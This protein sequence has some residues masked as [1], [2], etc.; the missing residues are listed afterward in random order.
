MSNQQ[1][2]VM[3]LVARGMTCREVSEVMAL[4][5]SSVRGHMSGAYQKLGVT[6][7]GAMAAIVVMKDSGWLGAFPRPPQRYDDSR[8]VTPAQ[9]AYNYCFVAMCQERTPR[10]AAI[11]TFAYAMLAGVY[12]IPVENSKTRPLG[13]RPADIDELLLRLARGLRRPIY[14]G[15]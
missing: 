6:G 11:V 12:R 15:L 8:D 10:A 13:R 9:L 1:F 7:R 3:T 14:D 2:R 4:D 5:A